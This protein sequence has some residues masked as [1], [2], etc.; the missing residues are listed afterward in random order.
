[1]ANPEV[2]VDIG[3]SHRAVHARQAS[4]EEHAAL[5]PRLVAN[6]GPYASY[7]RSTSRK[8]PLVILE[9]RALA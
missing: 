6:Y 3:R 7:Q 5:W 2:E 9:P 8:I 1:M 4:P